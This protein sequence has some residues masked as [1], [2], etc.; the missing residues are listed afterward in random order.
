[1]MTYTVSDTSRVKKF[2]EVIPTSS[3]TIVSVLYYFSFYFRA[4]FNTIFLPN[5][6]VL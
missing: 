4:Q 5:C 1:M 6:Y 2:R 3:L